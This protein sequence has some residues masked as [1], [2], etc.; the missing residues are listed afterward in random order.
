ML[1]KIVL[2]VLIFCSTQMYAQKIGEATPEISLKNANGETVSL[3]SLKGKVVLLDF[4]ASWCGPCRKAN[5]EF[6]KIYKKYKEQ[7]F[8]IYSVSVDGDAAKWKDA[9]AKDKITWTQVIDPGNWNS[10]TAKSWGIEALPT[11][12]LID[13]K[14]VLRHY[15]LEGKKLKSTIEALLKE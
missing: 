7:G 8:E 4:W 11:T 6:V 13:K 2:G 14:G 10:P 5:K 1:K 9:V 15:D 3:Q 12:F